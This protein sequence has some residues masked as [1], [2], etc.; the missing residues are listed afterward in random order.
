M[1]YYNSEQRKGKARSTP[2]LH[3]DIPLLLKTLNSYIY[4]LK[5][6]R[7]NTTSNMNVSK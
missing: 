5:Y 4:L 3:T 6:R 7:N 2:Q 1:N